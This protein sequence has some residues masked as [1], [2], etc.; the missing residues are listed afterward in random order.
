MPLVREKI[1]EER[2]VQT[3]DF[4]RLSR[5]AD[6]VTDVNSRLVRTVSQSTDVDGGV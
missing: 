2:C 4:N 1:E 5:I 3:V 6:L